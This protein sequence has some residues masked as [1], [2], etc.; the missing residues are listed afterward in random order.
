MNDKT[1]KERLRIYAPET[2]ANNCCFI[3]K[4][5][6]DG[7]R[8]ARDG[9]PVEGWKAVENKRKEYDQSGYKILFC[10]EFEEGDSS[11]G[12]MYDEESC[13]KLLELIVGS[14][15]DDYK[16][17]YRSKL[18]SERLGAELFARSIQSAEMEML[19]CSHL[20]GKHT[21]KLKRIVEEELR[22]EYGSK[23]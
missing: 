13:M 23:K 18:K 3:C 22:E 7:C 5:N 6:I 16:R 17:A 9:E 1:N 12:T 4:K 19:M 8:W 11:E 14:A 10:P 20:L 21:E 2:A 15:A